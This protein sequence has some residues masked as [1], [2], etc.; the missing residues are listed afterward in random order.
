MIARIDHFFRR[1]RRRFS[2]SEWG[3]HLLGLPVVEGARDEPGLVLIQIDGLSRRQMEQAMKR[4]RLPFLRRLVEREHHELRTFYPGLPTSTPA[5]QAELYYGVRCAVPAFGYF[6]RESQRVFTMNSPDSA[7]EIEARL[8][9]SAKGLLNGGSS[10]SNLYTGGASG[11]ESHFCPARMGFRDLFRSRSWIWLLLFA[12]FQFPALARAVLLLGV[13]FWI[14]FRDLFHGVAR[15][16]RL[17]EEFKAVFQRVFIC[18]GLRELVTIGT[19]IDVMRG[20]PIVHVNFLGYDEQSHRRGPASAFAHWSLGGI[21]RAIRNITRAANRSARRDYQVW[22]FSDHGQEATGFFDQHHRKSLEETISAAL[23]GL[24][25]TPQDR[26]RSLAHSAR[27]R[28]TGERERQRGFAEWFRAEVLALF[29]ERPFTVAAMGPVGHLYL[30]DSPTLDRK[31][32]IAHSLV[33]EGEV[34]SVLIGSASGIV[35]WIHLKGCSSLPSCCPDFLPQPES[36]KAELVRDLVRLGLHPHS[37]DL[38]L[39]GWG[40]G[41]P[42]LTF[43]HERGSH[44]GPGPDETQ[45]FLLVPESTW[46]PRETGAFVR[47]DQLRKAA[48]NALGREMLP[49]RR[50]HEIRSLPQRLR[51]MTYNVHG[52]L[53]MDGRISPRRVARLIERYHPDL[54]ALQELDFGRVR[55]Q[56]HDQARLIAETLGMHL[57]FCPTVIDHD[58]QYGHALLSRFPLEVL[59][60]EILHS[61]AQT[62]HVEPR[63]A[64]W[65]RINVEGVAVHLMN[66]HFG[67]RRGER[68]AQV[69]D[70]L[71]A[72]WIGGIDEKECLIV[73]GDFNMLPRSKPYRAL[74]RRLRDVQSGR[75]DF[76]PL[77][78]FSTLHPF[79]RIDHIFVSHHFTP[80]DIL[81][82]RNQLTRVTSDHLPLIADLGIQGSAS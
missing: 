60:T 68:A 81:V 59:R 4:G 20:L 13:E 76:A 3:I 38:I 62:L 63:G 48:L 10:W 39:L 22:V 50:R 14:A 77:N 47:P 37:G 80:T 56:R 58:E 52:C 26:L 44:A 6:E 70:L 2:R 55:S 19:K 29:E 57:A 64:L 35:E 24:E 71:G 1:W 27:S 79:A 73:C 74:T 5:V 67:L 21:D 78:T 36:I 42:S 33:Q 54:V 51:V 69:A 11:E 16:E 65:T 28:F 32:E 12:V 8:E 49:A 82:P 15:G 31:R 46:L 41:A 23:D 75:K 30:K 66:T 40:P 72:E 43:T 53:G 45:G 34:P 18:V 7:R 17:G 25:R 61:G 9:K